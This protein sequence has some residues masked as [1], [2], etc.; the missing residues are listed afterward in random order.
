MRYHTTGSN[1]RFVRNAKNR[2]KNVNRDTI[3]YHFC[4]VKA[5]L[6]TEYQNG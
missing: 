3:L 6:F 4:T 2:G 5:V 1:K